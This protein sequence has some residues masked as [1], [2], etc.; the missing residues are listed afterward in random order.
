MNTSHYR[1]YQ[2]ILIAST[3][4]QL[5]DVIAVVIKAG[6]ENKT[7]ATA[8]SDQGNNSSGNTMWD[9]FVRKTFT[10]PA[11]ASAPP[12][13]DNGSSVLEHMGFTF[14]QIILFIAVVC[15]IRHYSN[16]RI[17]QQEPNRLVN[18]SSEYDAYDKLLTSSQVVETRTAAATTSRRKNNKSSS[19]VADEEKYETAGEET[20][21]DAA[22]STK[23]RKFT[24][25]KHNTDRFVTNKRKCMSVGPVMTNAAAAQADLNE[26]RDLLDTKVESSGMF[27][28]MP[29]APRSPAMQKK[30]IVSK[31]LDMMDV[32]VL[33]P[34]SVIIRP[35]TVVPAAASGNF[36]MCVYDLLN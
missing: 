26:F 15:L 23:Q 32:F 4:C 27:N 21:C 35:S 20:D 16:M 5:H 8:T 13:P 3:Q 12:V 19:S 11:P 17:V 22:S 1:V 36:I 14:V 28:P 25:K 29:K 34:N 30:R 7:R 18:K 31:E 2:E 9:D 10:A 6:A 33:T 24:R